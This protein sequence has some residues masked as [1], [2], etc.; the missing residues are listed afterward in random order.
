M[1]KNIVNPKT[2]RVVNTH[3]KLG[4]KIIRNYINNYRMLGGAGISDRELNHLY[5]AAEQTKIREEEFFEK[6]IR[7]IE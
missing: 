2:G 5:D 4:K 1:Y 3:S 6:M 7:L